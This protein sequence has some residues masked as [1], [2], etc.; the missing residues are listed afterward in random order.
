M[1]INLRFLGSQ[2]KSTWRA[3]VEKQLKRLTPMAAISTASVALEQRSENKPPFRVQ[4]SLAVPGPDIHA[5]ASEYTFHAALRK[6][7]DECLSQIKKRKSK[8]LRKHQPRH[9]QNWSGAMARRGV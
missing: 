3:Q 7:I 9:W 8:L 1:K 2:P 4:A 5:E 6:V